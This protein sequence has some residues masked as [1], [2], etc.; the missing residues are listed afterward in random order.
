M[1]GKQEKTEHCSMR[2]PTW[3]DYV[4]FLQKNQGHFFRLL[5]SFCAKTEE[6]TI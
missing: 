1:S 4:F 2:K 3:R 5:L 6:E